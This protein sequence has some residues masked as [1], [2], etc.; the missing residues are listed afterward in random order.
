MSQFLR[1]TPRALARCARPAAGLQHTPRF[2]SSSIPCAAEASTTVSS[3]SS[4]S[5][6]S[7]PPT[8]PL[9]YRIGRSNS[10]NFPVYHRIKSGGTNRTT[11]VKK[12]E[13]D[14]IALSKRLTDELQLETKVNRRTNHVIIKG[15][16]REKVVQWL[17]ERGL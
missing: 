1:A 3:A 9:P 16:H 10:L 11:E 5:S 13:G 17:T 8:T 6:A 15:F 14:A 4:T 12:V 7:I 2:F